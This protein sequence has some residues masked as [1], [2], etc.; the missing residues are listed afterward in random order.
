[1]KFCGGNYVYPVLS[2][3]YGAVNRVLHQ[4]IHYFAPLQYQTADLQP[5]LKKNIVM[6]CDNL[7]IHYVDVNIM[8]CWHPLAVL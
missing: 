7:S 3:K 6:I 1:M 4:K 2:Q 8:I 5:H